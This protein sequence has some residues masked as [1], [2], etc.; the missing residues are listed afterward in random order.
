MASK[1]TLIRTL[2][3]E[4]FFMSVVGIF[5]SEPARAAMPDC[6]SGICIAD[7]LNSKDLMK[8]GFEKRE[9]DCGTSDFYSYKKDNIILETRISTSENDGQ[10]VGEIVNL[11]RAIFYKPDDMSFQD[12]VQAV[13]S[14]YGKE[15]KE[16]GNDYNNYKI[17]YFSEN[18][19][20]IKSIEIYYRDNSLILSEEIENDK[21]KIYY[22]DEYVN[23]ENEEAARKA[24]KIIPE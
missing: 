17:I 6:F 19:N 5:F 9:N 11:R 1:M 3:I 14:K 16:Y 12:L 21:H 18:K 22:L 20:L 10:S 8:K 7:L 15:G 24:E 4:I 13:I 23:C 2:K